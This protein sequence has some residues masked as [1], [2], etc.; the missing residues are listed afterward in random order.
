MGLHLNK[1]IT[2][3]VDIT[4]T[5]TTIDIM[6]IEFIITVIGIIIEIGRNKLPPVQ[7]EKD[8]LRRMTGM[9]AS[10]AGRRWEELTG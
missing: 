1:Y 3:T 6:R 7:P 8:R 2:T 4:H 9:D 5:A 10:I